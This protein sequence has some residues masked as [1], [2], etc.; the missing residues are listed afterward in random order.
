MKTKRIAAALLALSIMLFMLASVSAFA[1]EIEEETDAGV[2]EMLPPADETVQPPEETTPTP[3]P[4]EGQQPETPPVQSGGDDS[5][6]NPTFIGRVME[7]C[8]AYRVELISL[9][10]FFGLLAATFYNAY[11]QK[12]NGSSVLAGVTAIHGST[13]DV[14]A[15]QNGVVGAVNE[16]IG[17]YNTMRTSY[18]KYESAED[19]RN[20]LVGAMVVQSAA[21]LEILTAVYSNSKNLPQGVKDI[22]NL[23]YAKCLAT[24][25]NDDKLR[26][27]VESV[28]DVVKN[29]EAAPVE[30]IPT[31]S[32][33]YETEEE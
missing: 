32:D 13:S 18:D 3:E 11:T 31:E 30:E 10:G 6:A 14:A 28:R 24:L 29:E 23:K 25:Q 12:N 7:F 22:V 19:D 20:K 16:M 2:Q 15:A 5:A 26:A 4:G 9:A 27:F 8:T 17:A 21:I 1:A 33:E